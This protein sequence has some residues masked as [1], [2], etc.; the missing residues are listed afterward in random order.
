MDF[1]ICLSLLHVLHI[2]AFSFL[3][4]SMVKP[5]FAL[6]IQFKESISITLSGVATVSSV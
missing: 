4:C 5:V 3:L 6:L 2:S 1:F